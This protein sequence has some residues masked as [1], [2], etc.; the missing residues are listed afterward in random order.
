MSDRHQ[1]QFS[2]GRSLGSGALTS[3]NRFIRGDDDNATL[4]SDLGNDVL[5]RDDF[6]MFG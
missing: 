4:L 1:K 6:W 3:D 5:T 2:R